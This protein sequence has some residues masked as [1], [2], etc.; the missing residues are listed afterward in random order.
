MKTQ[1]TI[2]AD[3]FVIPNA[4]FRYEG[5]LSQKGGWD[6]DFVSD[7][8][9][10]WWKTTTEEYRREHD[11]KDESFVQIWYVTPHIEDSNWCAHTINGYKELKKGW[12][13]ISEY[14]PKCLFEGHK[15]GDCITVDLPIRKWITKDEAEELGIVCDGCCL[16]ATIKVQLQLAQQKYRYRRFGNFED[17]LARV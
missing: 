16:K 14:L 9:H 8:Y 2:I 5:S 13:P 4:S 10:V 15:E 17:V 3:V 7:L 12:R 11:F 1:E 6:T